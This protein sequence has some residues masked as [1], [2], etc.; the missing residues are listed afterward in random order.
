MLQHGA[1]GKL[2]RIAMIIVQK[3]YKK[4][5]RD[6][7]ALTILV[8]MITPPWLSGCLRHDSA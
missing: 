5:N 4:F 8:I 1:D 2:E 6:M 7:F 3:E